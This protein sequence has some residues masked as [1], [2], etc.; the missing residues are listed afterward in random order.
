[1]TTTAD[2]PSLKQT[3]K[4][5]DANFCQPDEANRQHAPKHQTDNEQSVNSAQ[6][7]HV[8]SYDLTVI[9][10]LDTLMGA[11]CLELAYRASLHSQSTHINESLRP[12]YNIQ[13]VGVKGGWDA[14][15]DSSQLYSVDSTWLDELSKHKQSGSATYH[16][17]QSIAST[18]ISYHDISANTVLVCL[19]EG[20]MAAQLLK[21]SGKHLVTLANTEQSP[22]EALAAWLNMPLLPIEEAHATYF[23][24][25]L[26]GLSFQ[27][28]PWED[29]VPDMSSK[30]ATSVVQESNDYSPPTVSKILSRERVFQSFSEDDTTTLDV[31]THWCG[32]P[33]TGLSDEKRQSHKL[34]K[35]VCLYLIDE[36][37]LPSENQR[38]LYVKYKQRFLETLDQDFGQWMYG[39]AAKKHINLKM[40]TNLVL[41]CSASAIAQSTERLAEQIDRVERIEFT[42]SKSDHSALQAVKNLPEIQGLADI[43]IISGKF[44]HY[45][46]ADIV[47][48][49]KTDS[50]TVVDLIVNHLLALSLKQDRPLVS[51]GSTFFLPFRLTK[52]KCKLSI[53]AANEPYNYKG[54]IESN[55]DVTK[56]H[57]D[58]SKMPTFSSYRGTIELKQGEGE[59]FNIIANERDAFLY[60]DPV[61]RERLFHLDEH[62][63]QKILKWC[64]ALSPDD[65]LNPDDTPHIWA[66]QHIKNIGTPDEQT[67]CSQA[68]VR[69]VSVHQFYNDVYILSVNVYERFFQGATSLT[70]CDNNWWHDLFTDDMQVQQTIEESRVKYWLTY[71]DKIRQIYPSFATRQHDKKQHISYFFGKQNPHTDC[72]FTQRTLNYQQLCNNRY[73][74]PPDFIQILKA[75]NVEGVDELRF[76]PFIDNRLFCNTIYGFAGDCL[77][78][79]TS[80]QH[81]EA[82][83]SLAAYVDAAENGWQSLGGYAYDP[84]FIKGLL[85]EQTYTRWAAMGNRYA[86]TDYSNVYI[87]YGAEFNNTIAP[88]HVFYNYQNMLLMALFYRESLHDFSERVSEISKHIDSASQN[89]FRK[90]RQDFIRFTNV[91]WFQELSSQIQGKELYNKILQGIDIK[92]EYEFLEKEISATYQHFQA[93]TADMFTKVTFA[94]AIVALLGSSYNLFNEQSPLSDNSVTPYGIP[95]LISYGL[96]LF[97]GKNFVTRT[98]NRLIGYRTR[99]A[100]PP[101]TLVERDKNIKN[102]RPVKQDNRGYWRKWAFYGLI[103]VVGMIIALATD[104]DVAICQLMPFIDSPE[105]CN[106]SLWHDVIQKMEPIQTK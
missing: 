19:P 78:N 5:R 79:D 40:P 104:S 69:D 33:I 18:S 1:M 60:L 48:Q 13:L 10:T 67:V 6:R 73:S 75:I 14:T 62:N 81:Y 65:E 45:F 53:N 90:I 8:A 21:S 27:G 72:P 59:R 23:R 61:I 38:S 95:L 11:D 91:S 101:N 52:R 92:K 50:R 56:K 97:V 93:V 100:T 98:A 77:V 28:I 49:N 63:G 36:K 25:Y 71:T 22:L 43:A 99:G 12:R 7:N 82:L 30:A 35:D 57:K 96:L 80:K 86:F 66:M 17:W 3:P 68:T 20:H 84:T 9:A 24:D 74:L 2:C 89:E 47:E 103:I 44:S 88:C 70:S 83:F 46:R 41:Y 105:Q 85:E 64:A 4:E 26:P 55:G 39:E 31:D 32:I 34:A 37:D 15:L 58:R 42:T 87:G 16:G 51:Y 106:W 76:K 54:L 29:S 102:S 94:I